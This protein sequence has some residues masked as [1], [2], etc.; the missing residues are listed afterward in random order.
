MTDGPARPVEPVLRPEE[1]RH[2]WLAG[3]L[4]AVVVVAI[5]AA[6]AVAGRGTLTDVV[7]GTVLY[8]GI[9]GV[10]AAVLAYERATSA[11]CPRCD[12]TGPRRRASCDACGYDLAERPLHRC[13]TRHPVY[14]EDGVC[15]CG[16]RLSPVVRERGLGRELTRILWAGAWVA[17]LLLGVWASLRFLY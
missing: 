3:A 1:R 7:V 17:A 13:P 16:Q 15:E 6:F 11:H 9:L 4:P 2:V 10:T 12:A 5:L 8:G 14:L